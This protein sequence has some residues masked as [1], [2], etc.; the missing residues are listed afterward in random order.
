MVRILN[1]LLP[2]FVALLGSMVAG[3]AA[4][5][6]TATPETGIELT[7]IAPI[8][9]D[10]RTGQLVARDN[11]RLSYDGW[12]LV[13]DEIRYSQT[14][15][16]AEAAG[17]V[18]IMKEGYRLLADKVEYWPKEKRVHLV[19]FR[20]GQPPVYVSADEARG[21]IED[22]EIIDPRIFYGEPDKLAPR[23]TA[24]SIHYFGDRKFK[25]EHLVVRLGAVPLFFV[26]GITSDIDFDDQYLEGYA[27]YSSD[28]GA[29][30]GLGLAVGIGPRLD[31]G[32][33]LGY[34]SERGLL[35]GPIVR[36]RPH[37]HADGATGDLR[38]SFIRD[39]GERGIDNLGEP[40]DTDRYFLTWDHLQTHGDRFSLTALVNAWS[41]SE[42]TR[43]FRPSL[44]NES[45]QPDTYAEAAYRGS[46]YQVSLFGRVQTN[47][48]HPMTERLPEVRF[49]LMPTAI[50]KGFIHELQ[51]SAARLD[52]TDP[53]DQTRLRSDRLDAYYGLSRAIRPQ[54]WLTFTPLI[55][56]RATHYLKTVD[57]SDH[58]TR[59]L[60]EIG[61]DAEIR[62]FANFD[63]DNEIWEINGL[64]HLVNTTIQYRYIPD[65]NKGRTIIPVIDREVF[66]TALP[67][68]SLAEIHP[69][70]DDLRD[71]NTVRLGFDNVLQTRHEDYGSRDLAHLYL[72]GDVRLDANP[73]EDDFSSIY[74]LLGFTPAPWLRA[75]LFTRMNPDTWKIDEL[76]TELRLIDLEFWQI[77]IG[78]EFL[79]GEF[80]QYTLEGRYRINDTF[81]VSGRV[82]YDAR[83]TILN[84]ASIRIE[85]NIRNLWVIEYGITA[86][87]GPRRETGNRLEFGLQFLGF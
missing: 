65:A 62:S 66:S 77:G 37:R 85:Q 55:G 49:D 1:S 3:V 5:E 17:N 15:S 12:L 33:S 9:Y 16:R 46:N 76:N 10:D 61:F 53:E 48:F 31:L 47:D 14:G 75:Q 21:T 83:T 2:A 28:L 86:Y 18:V 22:L 19:R 39:T 54:P 59:W 72:A 24:D 63:F 67:P 60:G 4:P 25:A 26:P 7:S 40:I 20:L 80:Q 36:Y 45:Q 23:A 42:V 87:D 11:A 44:F 56:G 34:F 68:L 50:G 73:G 30:G 51:L 35:W 29:F 58:Y 84:E 78:T 27:G 74:A 41:D 81:S 69:T 70:L 82:R 13:A 64:R 79:K 6:Q 43:D 71:T 8:E 57:G 32:G 52:Y 38:F